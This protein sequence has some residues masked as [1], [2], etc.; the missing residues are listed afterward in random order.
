M[1]RQNL[2]AERLGWDDHKINPE[3]LKLPDKPKVFFLKDKLKKSPVIIP[4]NWAG[5]EGTKTGR[6]PDWSW[7]IENV[8]DVTKRE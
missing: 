3:P 1:I 8:L 6:K 7:R 5:R 4:V 2:N